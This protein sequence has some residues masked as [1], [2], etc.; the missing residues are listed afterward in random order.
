MNDPI[1]IGPNDIAEAGVAL[2]GRLA[3]HLVERGYISHDDLTKLVLD[4]DE[5]LRAEGNEVGAAHVR[6]EC[7]VSGV[8]HHLRR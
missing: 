5:E 4:L 3:R 7:G 8:A 2:A 1:Q 6:S